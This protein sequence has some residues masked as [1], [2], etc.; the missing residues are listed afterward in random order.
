MMYSASTVASIIAPGTILL[1]PEAPIE[2]LLTDS[3]AVLFPATTLFFALSGPTK[4]GAQFLP[5]LYSIG[6]RNFVV[7]DL[8][9]LPMPV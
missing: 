7:A 3:R 2:H 6:V 4:N 1:Q 9:V 8:P 5:H